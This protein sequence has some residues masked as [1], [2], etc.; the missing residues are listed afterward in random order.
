[1]DTGK[2][3]GSRSYAEVAAS[4]GNDHAGIGLPQFGQEQNSGMISD[5]E[6]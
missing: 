4:E 1:M 2:D 3:V 5:D 6:H